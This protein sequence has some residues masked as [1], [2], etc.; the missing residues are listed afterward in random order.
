[1]AG[2]DVMMAAVVPPTDD[3]FR[4]F[5]TQVHDDVEIEDFVQIVGNDLLGA[6]VLSPADFGMAQDANVCKTQRRL[7]AKSPRH[8]VP[9]P[10]AGV[11]TVAVATAQ[12]SRQSAAVLPVSTQST[13]IG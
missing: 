5:L 11:V 8:A 7:F 3:E 1:M 13:P 10:A 9:P 6:K 12:V 4:A 2:M